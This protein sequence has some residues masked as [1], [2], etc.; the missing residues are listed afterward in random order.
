MPLP[1]GKS[2]VGR[3]STVEPQ[4]AAYTASAGAASGASTSPAKRMK[5]GYVLPS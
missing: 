1:L 2:T 3:L 5:V 4:A